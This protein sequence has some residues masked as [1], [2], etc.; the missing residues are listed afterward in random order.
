MYKL[1]YWSKQSIYEYNW[2]SVPKLTDKLGP[3]PDSD[4]EAAVVDHMQGREVGELLAGNKEERVEEV[5]ELRE[6]I[7]GG[8]HCDEDK[9]MIIIMEVMIEELDFNCTKK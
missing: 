5:E 2:D 4:G 6:E 8:E 3:E 1:P 7:P 9:Y